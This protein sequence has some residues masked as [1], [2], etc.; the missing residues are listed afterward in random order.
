MRKPWIQKRQGYKDGKP[1]Y[2]VYYWQNGKRKTFAGGIPTKKEADKIWD[3]ARQKLNAG[4]LGGM[5]E[6]DLNHALAEYEKKLSVEIQTG[7]RKMKVIRSF[8]DHAI[9]RPKIDYTFQD[10]LD[11][12]EWRK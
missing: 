7:D 3:V 2:D 8:I 4:V 10:V 11:Y 9:V 6:A 5:V 1:R 12:A